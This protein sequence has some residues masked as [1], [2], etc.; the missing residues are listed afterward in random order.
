[1]GPSSWADIWRP[2][3]LKKIGNSPNFGH[4]VHWRCLLDRSQNRGMIMSAKKIL[5]KS[6]QVVQKKE[7]CPKID[8]QLQSNKFSLEYECP[9]GAI[10]L[11][12]QFCLSESRGLQ[13]RWF[14]QINAIFTKLPQISLHNISKLTNIN[15]KRRQNVQF[16]EEK[17][18]ILGK[19]F[20][21]LFLLQNHLLFYLRL[22]YTLST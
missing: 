4:I 2:P 18:Q 13:Q 17:K 1:M 7:N 11:Y 16:Q 8:I 6:Y 9:W 22:A 10:P 15:H 14:V 21:T 19:Y 3:L 5:L 12:V 20:L